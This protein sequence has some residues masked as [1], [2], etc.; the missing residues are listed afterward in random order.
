[1][2]GAF[3]A[4]IGACGGRQPPQGVTHPDRAFFEACTGV[5]AV[6]ILT[7]NVFMMPPAL[8]LS[9]SNDERARTIA[10]VLRETDADILCLQKVFDASAGGILTRTLTDRF[11]FAYGP[12]NDHP[13]AAG[14][15]SGLIVLSRT[16]L[17]DYQAIE[18]SDCRG[19]ECL[20]AK[21]AVLLSAV[22]GVTTFRLI[23]THL[24]GEEGG[25]FTPEAQGVRDLQMKQIAAQLIEPYDE[26]GVPMFVCGDFGTPRF[27]ADG[28]RETPEYRRMLETLGVQ[29][30]ADARI[31]LNDSL[32]DNDLAVDNTGRRNELDYVFV[33]PQ[34]TNVEVAR[35]RHVFRRRGWDSSEADRRDL[36][37]RYA[38]SARISFA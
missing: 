37:Y 16:P 25:A 31:T 29:N 5:T 32:S 4:G 8:H 24:Q 13:C 10:G 12:A 1:M 3:A 36:S 2:L 6:T 20:S 18:F 26:A 23:V 14:P 38:V 11:P 33:H 19:I 15:N 22:C 35:T 21:G 9:P 28:T 30:G 17:A 7:W 27:T 34:G